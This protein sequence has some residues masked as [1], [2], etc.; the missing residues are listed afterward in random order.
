MRLSFEALLVLGIFGFYVYDSAMLLYF[1]E[2]TFVKSLRRWA[3]S[4]SLS[5]WRIGGKIP[6]L[7]NPLA[8]W[9]PLF[10]LTW[11]SNDQPLHLGSGEGL[12]RLIEAVRPVGYFVA[13]LLAEMLVGLPLVIF[14]FGT[15]V[16]FLITLAVIY[17][18][19]I[20]MLGMV[21]FKRDSLGLSGKAFASIVFDSIACPPFA[22]NMVRKISLRYVVRLNPVEFALQ[23]F[24]K[25]QFCLLA[26]AIQARLDEELEL[27]DVDSPLGETLKAYRNRLSELT[28]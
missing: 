6:Y 2:L 21:Y 17:L 20:G 24:E 5:R 28:A 27:V 19:I 12:T 1:N 3:F 8:P 4:C 25:E 18:T 9:N 16:E 10:R 13:V 15:G 26:S 14:K 22:I 23:H 11:S 7:P